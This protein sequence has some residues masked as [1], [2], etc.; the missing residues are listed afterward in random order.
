MGNKMC[1]IPILFC[2]ALV[3]S[4][5]SIQE[6]TAPEVRILTPFENAKIRWNTVVPYRISVSDKEDGNSE[7]EEINENE[8]VLSVTYF[9]DSSKVNKYV[10]EEVAQRS[11][12]L[13]AIASS[14]CFT[15]H[16]AKDRLIGPSFEE[17]VDRYAPTPE[18]L[19]YLAQKITRGSSGIWSDEI[20]PAQPEL[21]KDKIVQ[22]LDWILKN[23]KDPDYTFYNGTEGAF[24][25]GKG[26]KD[27]RHKAHYV[28][29]AQ[30]VDHG[31]ND[32]LGTSKKGIHS[33]VLNVE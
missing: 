15:C 21:E 28:L 23:A 32:S 1:S 4:F 31:L 33:I 24:K 8:V 30:Y 6:N 10:E 22:M 17:I 13:S 26:Q 11:E 7:Y 14:N 2:L 3:Y 5:L 27:G 29:H 19:E 18:N 12:V 20:M 9:G 25:T 16:R